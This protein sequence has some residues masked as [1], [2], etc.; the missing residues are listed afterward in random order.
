MAPT[1]GWVAR[2]SWDCCHIG[3]KLCNFR[4]IR[5]GD[6]MSKMDLRVWRRRLFS[7]MLPAINVFLQGCKYF[8]VYWSHQSGGSKVPSKTWSNSC[9]L[10]PT[11][12]KISQIGDWKHGVWFAWV[13]LLPASAKQAVSKSCF[14]VQSHRVLPVTGSLT[15]ARGLCVVSFSSAI[16]TWWAVS[17]ARS[18][19]RTCFHSTLVFSCSLSLCLNYLAKPCVTPIRLFFC[20]L[21]LPVGFRELALK[22]LH[23]RL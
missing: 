23:W 21:V 19:L 4:I 7:G 5:S 20:S 11:S 14:V 10:M 9:W 18:W 13:N 16:L 3:I 8:F 2:C 22:L 6:V 12:P 1:T 15:T 17:L